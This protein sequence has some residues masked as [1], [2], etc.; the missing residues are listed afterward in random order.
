[1]R[2]ALWSL[3]LLAIGLPWIAAAQGPTPD[4][5][6]GDPAVS[7]PAGIPLAPAT[8]TLAAPWT[9]T[10][11]DPAS[12]AAVL[13]AGNVSIA[14]SLDCGETGLRLMGDA[15]TPL[16]YAPG[17]SEYTGTAML[18]I[19]ASEDSLGDEGLDCTLV[20][21][22]RGLAD[23]T[24]AASEV[25]FHPFVAFQGRI[26]VT[27]PAPQRKAG[28][29]KIIPFE[30]EVKNLGNARTVVVFEVADPATGKWAF[31]VPDPVVVERGQSKSVT[32][33][34]ATP[35]H[36]GPNSGATDILL[37]ATPVSS[38][39]GDIRGPTVEVPLRAAFGGLYIP[40][41]SPALLFGALAFAAVAMRGSRRSR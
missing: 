25:L 14:W 34:V 11:E 30:V 15:T 8:A 4:L 38:L 10:F 6:L 20:A 35:Y 36:N 26:E 18:A 17:Q 41:P 13:A 37:R 21:E 1:M 23:A 40:G 24:S 5:T 7:G 12:A 39:D 3:L 27:A 19:A 31:L 32:F 29:D 28:P 22:A 16:S 33:S 9:Y 2:L